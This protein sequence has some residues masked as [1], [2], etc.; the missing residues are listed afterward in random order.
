VLKPKKK[1]LIFYMSVR[2]DKNKSKNDVYGG[3]NNS[4]D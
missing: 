3:D 4:G 2:V 1:K